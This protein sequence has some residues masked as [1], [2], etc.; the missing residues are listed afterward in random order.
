MKTDRPIEIRLHPQ[1]T[2]EVCLSESQDRLEII[3][4][5]DGAAVEVHGLDAFD[6][7]LHMA[8]ASSRVA[9]RVFFA[10]TPCPQSIALPPRYEVVMCVEK[11]KPAAVMWKNDA[12]PDPSLN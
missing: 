9:I 10:D 12:G 4:Q 7:F 8:N 5:E 1:S 11:G 3:A 2:C 6:G